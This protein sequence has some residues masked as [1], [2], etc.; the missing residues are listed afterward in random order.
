MCYRFTHWNNVQWANAQQSNDQLQNSEKFKANSS[1]T[2]GVLLFI[3]TT[4]R[5]VVVDNRYQL[6][7]WCTKHCQLKNKKSTSGKSLTQQKFT[8][9][10]RRNLKSHVCIEKQKSKKT[11]PSLIQLFAKS[12]VFRQFL[13]VFL[14]VYSHQRTKKV[15]RVRKNVFQSA[16]K[17]RK[18][19]R[20]KL[21]QKLFLGSNVFQQRWTIKVQTTVL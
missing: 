21:E 6:S 12:S 3:D 17:T 15:G 14:T 10:E 19:Q 9:T 7:I 16:S 5:T 2:H 13:I 8:T 1:I 11:H 4:S 18:R 20:E